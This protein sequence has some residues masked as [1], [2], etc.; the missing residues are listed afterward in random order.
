[1]M[2]VDVERIKEL[3]RQYNE[4]EAKGDIKPWWELGNSFLGYCSTL[5]DVEMIKNIWV[6]INCY[7]MAHLYGQIRE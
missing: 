7:G 6:A 4:Y 5:D 1:M 2:T 3:Q